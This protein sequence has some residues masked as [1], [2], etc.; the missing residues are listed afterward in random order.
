MKKLPLCTLLGGALF[1]IFGTIA[2]MEIA[3][4]PDP[5]PLFFPLAWDAIM[6]AIA[7]GIILRCDC[8]RRA[9]LI[10][11]IFC[12]LASLAIGAAALGWLWPQQTEPMGHQRMIFMGLTVFFGFAF[13]IWQLIAF[14]SPEVRAW[15]H[16]AA[17][18]H[19]HLPSSTQ[20]S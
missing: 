7:S 16:P 19:G 8:A 9:G 3:P 11:G 13:G 20:H 12:L 17:P 15:T 2:L 5:F 10:W 6:V 18:R 14:N 4:R 1:A